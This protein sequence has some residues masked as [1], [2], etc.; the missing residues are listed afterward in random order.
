[1]LV[2]PLA[3]VMVTAVVAASLV[4]CSGGTTTIPGENAGDN[5]GQ[6]VPAKKDKAETAKKPTVPTEPID[7]PKA[8]P[9]AGTCNLKNIQFKADACGT[10]VNES[11]CDEWTTCDK[12]ADCLPLFVCAQKCQGE[13][14]CIQ[15][16]VT[17]YPTG[18]TPLV[19]ATKCI[20]AKCDA[21]CN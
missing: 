18:A 1:M 10:C 14:A 8:E 17:M 20:T 21:K 11:C 2:R 19:T 6:L 5:E 3:F 13:Q 16:C 9:K 7:P 4:A 12:N 15:E